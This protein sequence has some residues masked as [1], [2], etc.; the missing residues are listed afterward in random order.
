MPEIEFKI[1]KDGDDF[2]VWCPQLPGCHSHGSTV[3]IAMANLKDAVSLYLDVLM[4][5][6]IANQLP[7]QH[8]E[9][10]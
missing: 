6:A 7:G 8:N 3:A 10:A 9:A 2:H 4:E 5:D 1:E